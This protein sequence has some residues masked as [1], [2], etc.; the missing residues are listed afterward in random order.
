M[1]ERNNKTAGN[2]IH[3]R[4]AATELVNLPS[5][6][7]EAFNTFNGAYSLLETALQLNKVSSD[8]QL[9]LR[10]M[11][12]DIAT[13]NRKQLLDGF[14]ELVNGVYRAIP[15]D[16]L[17]ITYSQLKYI[18]D[19]LN[20]FIVRDGDHYQYSDNVNSDTE[21]CAQFE[22]CI[23]GIAQLTERAILLLAES[24]SYEGSLNAA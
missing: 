4:I 15:K 8:P 24:F 7:E 22:L 11:M 19:S 23:Y 3:N 1:S 20:G 13:N 2:Q 21:A 18:D 16:K 5:S 12:I 10:S 9:R 6:V 17:V 14:K